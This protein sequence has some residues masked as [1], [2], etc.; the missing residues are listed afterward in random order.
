M[1]EESYKRFSSSRVDHL[2]SVIV[3]VIV[4]VQSIAYLLCFKYNAKPISEFCK[5]VIVV[6]S[7]LSAL[8]ITKK[9]DR[10]RKP[11]CVLQNS[12]KMVIYGQLINLVSSLISGI[13]CYITIRSNFEEFRQRYGPSFQN[14][15]PILFSIQSILILYGPL[16]C[17]AELISC[18]LINSL[19]YLFEDWME[20][21]QCDQGRINQFNSNKKD[22]TDYEGPELTVDVESC[23]M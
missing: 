21:I 20:L 10:K 15:Y 11:C 22:E 19:S 17:A 2:L 4:I 8:I 6:K 9:K 14:V 18:E 1:H 23:E 16:S 5:E 13:W 7:K 3:I 12:E